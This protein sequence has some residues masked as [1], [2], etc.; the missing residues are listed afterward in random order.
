MG[1]GQATAAVSHFFLQTRVG[2]GTSTE[3]TRNTDIRGAHAVHSHSKR[4]DFQSSPAVF[5]THHLPF[6]L[7]ATELSFSQRQPHLS[8]L[9]CV[10]PVPA[11]R[12]SGETLFAGPGE[13]ERGK[14]WRVRRAIGTGK[15]AVLPPD[16][17]TF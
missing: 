7:L 4:Q 5:Y 16:V 17:L 12:E 15:S 6:Y 10:C 13:E 14:R 3:C 8:V 2:E 1:S 9:V 11:A